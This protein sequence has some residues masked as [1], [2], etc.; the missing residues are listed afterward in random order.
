MYLISKIKTVLFS[1]IVLFAFYSCKKSNIV[2]P[3]IT[4]TEESIQFSVT[5]NSSTSPVEATSDS[6]TFSIKIT[7]K[8]PTAGIIPIQKKWQNQI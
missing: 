4:E 3:P 7:S 6:L 8:I 2:N 5:P 1:S